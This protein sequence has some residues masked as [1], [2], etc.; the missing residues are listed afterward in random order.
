M[1]MTEKGFLVRAQQAHISARGFLEAHQE[2]LA[3]GTRGIYLAPILE[4]GIANGKPYVDILND[5]CDAVLALML[6]QK[7]MP[8]VPIIDKPKKAWVAIV[9]FADIPK[10][11]LKEFDKLQ[12]AERWIDNRLISTYNE[13]YGEIQFTKNPNVVFRISKN[14]SNARKFP[15][16]KHP[17]SKTISRN[18]DMTHMSVKTSK[19]TFS[20][21]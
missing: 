21:G 15:K 3:E 2:W 10:P 19:V 16:K 1:G 4:A 7:T 13:A 6:A 20:H 9:T 12:E 8:I 18:S 5:V 11:L 17:F 14:E